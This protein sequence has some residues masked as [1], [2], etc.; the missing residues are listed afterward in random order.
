[1]KRWRERER[2]IFEAER[3]IEGRIGKFL[4]RGIAWK[5]GEIKGDRT[6]KM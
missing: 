4:R 3:G 1:M 2:D 5:R 6:C